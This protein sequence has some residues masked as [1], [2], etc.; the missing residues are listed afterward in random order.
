MM[1]SLSHSPLSQRQIPCLYVIL[2][3]KRMV[4]TGQYEEEKGGWSDTEKYSVQEI[5]GDSGYEMGIRYPGKMGRTI[6]IKL[7]NVD[8]WVDSRNAR[9]R[10]EKRIKGRYQILRKKA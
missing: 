6:E 5:I 1:H 7:C 10:K 9:T 3:R 4:W 2:E 8:A